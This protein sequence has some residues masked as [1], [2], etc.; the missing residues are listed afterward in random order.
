[1]VSTS[2]VPQTIKSVSIPEIFFISS[3]YIKNNAKLIVAIH[4]KFKAVV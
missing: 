4:G 1:M 3:F 2:E